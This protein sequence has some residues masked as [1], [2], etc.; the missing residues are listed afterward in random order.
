MRRRIASRLSLIVAVAGIL[1]T[2]GMGLV[3]IEF[4]R[5]R[6][7]RAAQEGLSAIAIQTALRTDEY[8]A[9]QKELVRAVAALVSSDDAAKRLKEV[10]LDAPSLGRVN[11]LAGDSP[12]S[13]RPSALDAAA[14]AR[15]FAGQEVCSPVYLAPDTT[16][17]MD[18]CTPTPALAGRV[19]CAR[20]DLLELWRFVQRMQVGSSGYALVLDGQGHLLASGAGELREAIL[21][22]APVL[23]SAMARE[24]A[25]SPARAPTH[26]RGG[27]G[28]DVIA[29]WAPL[30]KEGWVV[31]VEQPVR[32][33]LRAART[34]QWALGGALLLAL[35]LSLATG[36]RQSL[37]MMQELELEERWRTAGRIA[38]GIAHDLGHRLRVLQQTAELAEAANPAFLPRI[39]DNLRSELLTL[40]KFVTEFSDLSR[41]VKALELVPLEVGAFL[42]SV[43]KTTE[44]FAASAGVA[45]KVEEL[46]APVW[47]RADRYLFERATLNLISNAVEA[48]P[49]GGVVRLQCATEA[50]LVRLDVADAGTGIPPERLPRLFDAFA[51]TKRTGAHLGMGLPNVKRIVE[52]HG[53]SVAVESQLGKGTR[54]RLTLPSVSPPA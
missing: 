31:V 10:V 43:Q 6:S 30:P 50:G 20:L 26:Y 25:S 4:L 24:A 1:P 9:H 19:V 46:G 3:G 41:D 2:A 35:A 14:L 52:A 51:S 21:T 23:E 7:E 48:S 40:K 54:F 16:P 13:E 15:A 17:A 39:R 27:Q 12:A 34:A 49:K 29:A 22:G 32:E 38:A 53:G 45:V 18:V 11:L 36:L 33:A 42:S 5:R 28:E 47:V 44:G 8:L 37:R